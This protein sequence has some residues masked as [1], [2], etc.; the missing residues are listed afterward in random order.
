MPSLDR[1]CVTGGVIF[2]FFVNKVTEDVGF[3]GAVRYTALLMGILLAVSCCL[4]T[5]RLPPK[6][7][8]SE[9]KWIDFTLLKDRS[10]ALYTIGAFFVMLVFAM[11]SFSLLTYL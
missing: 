4:I 3:Y 2:P 11:T 8:D 7:W 1:L 10:F 9:G 6:P 5:A